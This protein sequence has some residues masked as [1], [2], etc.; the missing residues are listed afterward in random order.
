MGAIVVQRRG[1]SATEGDMV[2]AGWGCL[3]FIAETAIMNINIIHV[4]AVAQSVLLVTFV[5]YHRYYRLRNRDWKR[6]V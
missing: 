6:A 5:F 1:E 3:V 2:A 4:L